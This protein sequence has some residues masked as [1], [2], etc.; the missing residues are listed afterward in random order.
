LL[1]CGFRTMQIP[2]SGF[3]I[4]YSGI[5]DWDFGWGLGLDD[6]HRM[7]PFKL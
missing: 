5:P 3:R 1:G 2:D 7:N 6:G 4:L